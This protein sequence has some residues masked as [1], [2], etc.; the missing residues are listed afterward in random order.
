MA[1]ETTKSSPRILSGPLAAAALKESLA[2]SIAGCKEAPSL[3]VMQVGAN[4]AS[5]SYIRQKQKN[6]LEWGFRFEHKKLSSDISISEVAA[7]LAIVQKNFDGVILQLPLDRSEATS[8]DA[9]ADLLA[10]IKPEAD[11]DGLHPMNLG[12]VASAE[13]T[14]DRW[15]SPIPAT[16]MGVVRMLDHYGVPLKGENVTIIGKSRLVGMPLAM[17]LMHR[18]ATVSVCHSQTKDLAHYT[19]NSSLVVSA[20][21]YPGLLTAKHFNGTQ[22]VIDVGTTVV[23]KKLRGDLSPEAYTSVAAYSP[24]PGGVGPMTV[25]ALMENTLRLHLKKRGQ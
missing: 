21:G 25:A 20:A 6:A 12:R 13:S 11:A 10:G 17:L 1:S 15:T 18:G 2:A 23:D 7:Q 5:D 4:P 24:V 8:A 9:V 16:A 14:A 22:T 3:C 19:K